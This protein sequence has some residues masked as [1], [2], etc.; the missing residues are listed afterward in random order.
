MGSDLNDDFPNQNGAEK[1]APISEGDMIRKCAPFYLS[2]GMTPE[3]FFHGDAE[4]CR[5][6]RESDRLKRERANEDAWLQ[7][8]YIYHAL[9]CVSPLYRDLVKDHH[10]EK[11]MS[12]PLQLFAP[13]KE[14]ANKQEI[15]KQ[16]EVRGKLQA[17][18]DKVN[19]R[20]KGKENA[21]A[22]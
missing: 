21:N 3:E 22:R 13:T 4:L 1:S 17:W 19:R 15:Q 8:L 5:Y 20:M 10:P 2:I 11:Y 7:G 18:M 14:E 9:Q 16:L 6:Y 12:E